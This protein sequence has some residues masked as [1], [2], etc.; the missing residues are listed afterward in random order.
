MQRLIQ[1]CLMVML[2]AAMSPAVAE[3]VR[4]PAPVLQ[5]SFYIFLFFAAAVAIG[6]FFVRTRPGLV[7]E[8][9]DELIDQPMGQVHSVTPHAS[10]KEA[11]ELMTKLQIG[12]LLVME[13]DRLAGVFSERDCMTRVVA[14]G[15]DPALTPVGLVMTRD[16]YCI[17]PQT[18]LSDA[19]AV[20]T[21][22]RIRHLPVVADGR[23]LGIVTSGDLILRLAAGDETQLRKAAEA[24]AHQTD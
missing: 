7:N 4:L 16:P 17:S 22:Y 24:A 9:L 23:V 2:T 11:V 10:V 8:P 18:T 3:D 15:R 6:I 21:N 13:D 12:A 20:V 14:L 1:A 5:W 19:L